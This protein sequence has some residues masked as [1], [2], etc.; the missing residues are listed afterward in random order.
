MVINATYANDG[1]VTYRRRVLF[2]DMKK[3]WAIGISS[4][5]IGLSWTFLSFGLKLSTVAGFIAWSSFFAAG[6]NGMNG[7]KKGLIA[8]ISGICWGALGVFASNMLGSILGETE[9]IAITNG[10]GACGIILQSKLSLLAFIPAAFLGWSA[11]IASDANF[12]LTLISM[13][14][15]SF[16]GLISERLT[17]LILIIMRY[18]DKNV[19]VDKAA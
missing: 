3:L 2:M 10:V 5:I 1:N 7:V 9:R 11:F 12:L 13:A 14:C 8:N 19:S 15:G 4:G 6:G 18:E 16:A 17:D